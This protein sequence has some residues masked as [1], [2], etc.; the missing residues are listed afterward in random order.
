MMRKKGG[1]KGQRPE[2]PSVSSLS[3]AVLPIPTIAEHLATATDDYLANVPPFLTVAQCRSFIGA[4][5]KL[6]V[7]TPQMSENREGSIQF[8]VELLRPAE[9]RPAVAG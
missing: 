6:I 1:G 7:L 3:A 8:D 2:F 4:C 9:G 5:A